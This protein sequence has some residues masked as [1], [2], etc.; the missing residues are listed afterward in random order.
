[1]VFGGNPQFKRGQFQGGDIVTPTIKSN[2]L[3]LGISV[4]SK[5]EFLDQSAIN[6]VG[7]VKHADISWQKVFTDPDHAN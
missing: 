7:S 6:T 4:D 3:G 2:Q 5:P 1:M